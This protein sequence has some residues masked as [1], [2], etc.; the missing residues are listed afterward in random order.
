MKVKCKNDLV[1]GLTVGNEY[2]VYGIYIRKNSIVYGI[3]DDY[4]VMNE[5]NINRFGNIFKTLGG[6]I[7][8]YEEII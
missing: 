8:S 1:D 7:F 5:F 2:N 6:V 4:G 3:I